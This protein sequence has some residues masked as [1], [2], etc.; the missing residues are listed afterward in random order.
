MNMKKIPEFDTESLDVKLLVTRI[1]MTPPV[2]HLTPEEVRQTLRLIQLEQA[3]TDEKRTSHFA[4][5][6][7][8]E[9]K[10]LEGLSDDDKFL[11]LLLDADCRHTILTTKRCVYCFGGK[12]YNWRK[13]MKRCELIETRSVT[14]EGQYGGH[15]LGRGWMLTPYIQRL[16]KWIKENDIINSIT[17]NDY[18]K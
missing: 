11:A 9:D 13:V 16:R 4:V 12:T 10:R 7:Y 2:L 5:T 15:Y 1:M 18:E 6:V 3:L 8:Q 14:M 17:Q